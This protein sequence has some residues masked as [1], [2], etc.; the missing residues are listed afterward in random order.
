MKL[1][2][3]IVFCLSSIAVL[4][5]APQAFNYQAVLREEKGLILADQQTSLHFSLLKGSMSGEAVY[6]ETQTVVTNS[7]GAFDA[8]IGMGKALKGNFAVIDWSKGPYF[9]KVEI[10]TGSGYATISTSQL[11]SVPY[12][13]YSGSSKPCIDTVSS[14]LVKASGIRKENKYEFTYDIDPIFFEQLT[15]FVI[16]QKIYI[17][18]HFE[19]GGVS[20]G[21]FKPQHNRIDLSDLSFTGGEQLKIEMFFEAGGCTKVLV[22]DTNP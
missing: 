15:S 8:Q 12:A 5:Q 4:A 13:L 1:L 16:S 17:N 19:R 22:L 6:S 10:A 20:V 21:P 9:L 11:L 2:L 18:G 7:M 14:S 3:Y